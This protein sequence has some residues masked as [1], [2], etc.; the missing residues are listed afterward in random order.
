MQFSCFPTPMITGCPAGLI[1][2]ISRVNES[3]KWHRTF[4]RSLFNKISDEQIYVR[5]LRVT[6]HRRDAGVIDAVNELL[7]P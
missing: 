3:I 4:T 2:Q 5:F 7:F 6:E 1:R